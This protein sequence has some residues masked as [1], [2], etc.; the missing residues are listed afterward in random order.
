MGAVVPHTAAVDWLRIL[1][2]RPT[3][4]TANNVESIDGFIQDRAAEK[5]EYIRMFAISYTRVALLP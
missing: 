1:G 4:C 2:V 3:L 5:F